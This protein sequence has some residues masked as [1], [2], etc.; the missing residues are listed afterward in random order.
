[1]GHAGGSF[2]HVFFT[3]TARKDYEAV[4][5]SKLKRGIHRVIE[6]L[7]ED[8]YQFKQLSGPLAG[9][10]SA[11]TFSFRVIYRIVARQLIVVVITIEHRKDV[12]R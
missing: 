4:R 1:M 3:A 10:R 8:P 11:K 5:D 7:K 6:K 12:Y 9:L 2:F